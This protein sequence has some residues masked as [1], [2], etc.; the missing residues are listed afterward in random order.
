MGPVSGGVDQ[1]PLLQTTS[2]PSLGRRP[3]GSLEPARI[4]LDDSTPTSWSRR[5]VLPVGQ[6]GVHASRATTYTCGS[7][8]TWGS[9]ISPPSWHHACHRRQHH[10]WLQSERSGDTDALRQYRRRRSERAGCVRECLVALASWGE[11]GRRIHVQRISSGRRRFFVR[12]SNP[13]YT[14]ALSDPLESGLDLASLDAPRAARV[15]ASRPTNKSGA[16]R[17]EPLT[18]EPPGGIEPPTCSLRVSR[19]GRLS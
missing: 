8:V 12:R 9:K 10:P 6:T 3:S 17:G 4:V 14:R 13:T 19:S 7:L 18:W 2:K 1:A 5:W 11:C 15:R 16:L